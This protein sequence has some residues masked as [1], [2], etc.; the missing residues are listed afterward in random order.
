M[1]FH[2]LYCPSEGKKQQLG[3]NIRPPGVRAAGRAHSALAPAAQPCQD[4]IDRLFYGMAGLTSDEV[5]ALEERY[6]RM[7]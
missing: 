5:K 4:F 7:L 2:R 3:R 1:P 6:A